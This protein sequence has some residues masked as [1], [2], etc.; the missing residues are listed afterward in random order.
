MKRRRRILIMCVI[1]SIFGLPFF[2]SLESCNYKKD[3]SISPNN[4]IYR[5]LNRVDNFEEDDTEFALT[6]NGKIWKFKAK[7]FY[8]T[9]KQFDIN[10]EFL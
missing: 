10:Y 9:Y 6:Y 2:L 7:D 3:L 1:I 5:E 8:T 4:E